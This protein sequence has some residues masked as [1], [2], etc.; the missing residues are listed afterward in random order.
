MKK[1]DLI[2]W[3]AIEGVMISRLE[4]RKFL[5]SRLCARDLNVVD[6]ELS[7]AMN[8]A[9]RYAV[10]AHEANARRIKSVPQLLK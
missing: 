6:I 8:R 2:Y 10:K 1:R 5:E 3:A 9:G 4:L 7:N